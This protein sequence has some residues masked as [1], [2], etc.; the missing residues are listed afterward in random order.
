MSAGALMVSAPASGHGKTTVTAALAR[1][2]TDAGLCVRVFKT[3]PDF[4]DPMVLE[5]AVGSPV[6][7][8]D[9]WMGGPEH[10][11]ALLHRAAVEADVVLVEGAMGL[12]DGTP[13]SADLA[14]R[15]GLPV[16]AVID[17]SA[18]AQTFGALALG[19]ATYRSEPGLAGVVAN[20]SAGAV[21]ARMLRESLPPSLRFYGALPRDA[22]FALPSRH[23]G[24]VQAAEI[25]D[26]EARIR[27]AAAALVADGPIPPPPEV[28]L[29][30]VHE[31][32][33]PRRLDGL[34]V[35][36]AR[37][38]AFAFL[39]EANLDV[40]RALGATPCPF[41]P[42]ADEPVPEGCG[43]LYLPGGYP[44]LHLD[45]LAGNA[46][47]RG[48]V[49][50]HHAAG[51]PILA[52]CGGLLWLLDA[53][54]DTQGRRAPMLGLLPGAARV[55]ERLANI[56]LQ[57]L[58]LPEGTLRGQTFHHASAEVR[59]APA[60]HTRAALDH[61]R[62]EPVWRSGR[63]VASFLHLYFPSNPDAIAALLRP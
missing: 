52:E 49:L 7:Q 8:L 4:L 33:P 35:A 58:A 59:L 53:L 39:Y 18:M 50:A 24:L 14:R 29:P 5:R 17:A 13:S 23:L 30:E 56:G 26:L 54:E 25:A 38:A 21:H 12:Y 28:R 57:T 40:L 46:V 20:R 15:F 44:E 37:D 42:L 43:A 61:G 3:G 47:T 62:P 27:A 63:L 32:V 55:G 51:R 10:C 11:A 9:L 41:S 60:A 19:L 1:A 6:R 48:S 34:R 22:G 45:A 36:V 16:L 2:W 31:P